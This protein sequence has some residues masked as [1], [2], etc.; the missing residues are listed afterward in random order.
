[1]KVILAILGTFLGCCTNV[2]VLEY[3]VKMDPGSGNLVT[4]AQFAFIA[5]EG[6][7]FTSKF[8]TE[9]LRIPYKSYIILVVMFFIASVCN[10]YA[11]DFN[12]PMPLHMIFRAGSLIAN[13][14]MGI[15]ILRK[16]YA[17][18]KYLSVFMISL[19]IVICTIVSGS[20]VRSTANPELGLEDT[21]GYSVFFWWVCGISLLTLALFIS[22]RMGIYQEVLYKQHGKH[23]REALYMS[24]LL[25]LPGFLLMY[26]NIAEHMAI[27]SASEPVAVPIVGVSI[28]ILWL[29]LLANCLTQYLCISSVFVLTTECSSLTV[30]LVVTLRKFISLLFS[31]VYFNNPF[32]IYHWIG[33]L[34]VFLGTMIFTEM[35]PP[36]T[37][38]AAAITASKKSKQN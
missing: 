32:T 19:G 9:P 14:V 15:I 13:M 34:L 4:F 7:I 10:N 6:L 23:P 21:S 16:S 27:A 29:Y 35:L 20:N 28:P 3:M 5:L 38:K 2:V 18:S 33:T 17:F 25:P 30:T 8:G 37:N 22:A 36:F 26:S 24:H 1:M 31:I 11:F 12:I